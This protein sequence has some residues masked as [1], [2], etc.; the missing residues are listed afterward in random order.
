VSGVTIVVDGAPVAKGR[1]RMTR[2]GHAFTP[3]KTRSY[4]S[5][6]KMSASQAMTGREPMAGNLRLS[7][8]ALLP[9]PTSWSKRKQEEAAADVLRPASR[10]D[11]DNYCKAAMDALN[12]VVWRDDSQIVE[13]AASKHYSTK[14]GLMIRVDPL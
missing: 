7:L 5:Y 12:E 1:A 8:R 14:P 2:A 3:A 4:E 11:L 6:V 13:L 10:P 9:I